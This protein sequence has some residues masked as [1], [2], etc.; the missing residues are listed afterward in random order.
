MT[1]VHMLSG[2]SYV[3]FVFRGL[4]EPQ[5][6]SKRRNHAKL[7][8]YGEIIFS[9]SIMLPHSLPREECS[10]GYHSESKRP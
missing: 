6:R 7:N 9:N 4:E 10:A 8:M 1:W 5:D 2:I 3:I